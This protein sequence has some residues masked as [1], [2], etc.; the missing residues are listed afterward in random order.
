M[1]SLI[2]SVALAVQAVWLCL[3]LWQ[4]RPL[5]AFWRE[6][7]FRTPVLIFES[8]DWG[9]APPD[10]GEMLSAIAGL[11]GEF[12]DRKGRHP[13]MTLA[14]V[15]AI[16]E[17]GQEPVDGLSE[18]TLAEP[19]FTAIVEAMRAGVRAGVFQLHLHGGSHY[20]REALLAACRS[21]TAVAGWLAGSDT[22]R[23]EALPPDLQSRWEPRVA[24]MPFRIAD[25]TAS[26]A[27]AQ[28][29]LLFHEC[30]GTQAII[31]VPNRFDWNPAVERGW[32][33]AGVRTVVTPGRYF[34]HLGQ[35]GPPNSFTL[36]TNGMQSENVRYVVRD[37]YFEPFKGHT[38]E[39]GLR[40]LTVNTALSRP[41]LLE[42]HRANFLDGA[43]RD[44]S[45]ESMRELLGGALA[46]YPELRFL[47]TAELVDAID[48]RRPD[49][50]DQSLRGRLSAWCVRIRTQHRFWKL[51]RLTGLAFVVIATEKVVGNRG[52]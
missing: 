11:L 39:D 29:A 20:W 35:F 33:E 47:S 30:L 1:L 51:A 15:L 32:G 44:R 12:S 25:E 10:H 46:R 38:V 4:R 6:P 24:G 8:D 19:Q 34:G 14:V 2:A 26:A 52:S 48:E 18:L 27:A 17:P 9:P 31:A 43:M 50:I 21:D 16:P 13:V 37:Q 36:I 5:I 22:W 45:L 3:L 7:V 23:T 28:D 49:L 41:T 40:A 42:T